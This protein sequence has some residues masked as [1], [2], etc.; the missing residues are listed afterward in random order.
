MRLAKNP[1]ELM[2][3]QPGAGIISDTF[4]AF[5]SGKAENV[6]GEFKLKDYFPFKNQFDVIKAKRGKL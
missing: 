5:Y 4:W 1:N 6:N 2:A 3:A